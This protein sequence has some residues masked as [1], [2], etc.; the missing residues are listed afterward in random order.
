[1]YQFTYRTK[2]CK[3]KNIPEIAS[4]LSTPT[5]ISDHLLTDIAV[6]FHMR[7]YHIPEKSLY[8]TLITFSLAFIF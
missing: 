8:I 7:G 5:L 2:E 3:R 6:S 4:N 1:M